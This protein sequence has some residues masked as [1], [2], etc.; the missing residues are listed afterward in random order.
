MPRLVQRFW[1]QG[2]AGEFVTYTGTDFVGCPRTRRS[3]NGGAVMRGSHLLKHFSKTQKVVTL[4]SAEAELGG[5]VHGA[6]E[7]MGVQSVA[8][9]LGVRLPLWGGDPGSRDTPAPSGSRQALE[10]CAPKSGV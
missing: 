3:T 9:D 2:P 7:G 10:A 4:S 8:S 5:I 1:W 6:A